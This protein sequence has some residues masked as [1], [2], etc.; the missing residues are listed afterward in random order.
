[1]TGIERKISQLQAIIL[2]SNDEVIR[3]QLENL[4]DRF[5]GICGAIIDPKP[6]GPEVANSGNDNGD[7]SNT[8]RTICPKCGNS[9]TIS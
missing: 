3:T 9:L 2:K 5:I 4:I 8:S 7:S 1:M 6:T